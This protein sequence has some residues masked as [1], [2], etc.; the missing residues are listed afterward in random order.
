MIDS[1]GHLANGGRYLIHAM[2]VQALPS[3]RRDGPNP[4]RTT[5][6]C[7]VCSKAVTTV[8]RREHSKRQAKEKKDA[9]GYE[10]NNWQA[11]PRCLA[12]D[13]GLKPEPA[14]ARNMRQIN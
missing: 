5:R 13:G 10:V 11:P 9:E 1:K 4:E 2:P 14:A 12:C 7:G 6:Y 3:V 8:Q